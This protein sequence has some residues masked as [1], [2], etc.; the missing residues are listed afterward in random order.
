M[1]IKQKILYPLFACGFFG[2]LAL[3][4]NQYAIQQESSIRNLEVSINKNR[5]IASSMQEFVSNTINYEMNAS[6]YYQGIQSRFFTLM[7]PKLNFISK[8]ICNEEGTGHLIEESNK[9]ICNDFQDSIENI[10]SDLRN[11]LRIIRYEI[12]TTYKDLILITGKIGETESLL[13]K[14][15]NELDSLINTISDK[16]NVDEIFNNDEDL[17]MALNYLSQIRIFI[18][19]YS[20]EIDSKSVDFDE[21][22]MEMMN[23]RQ[24]LLLVA[25]LLQIISLICLLFFFKQFLASRHD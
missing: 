22:V 11:Y 6:S 25:V 15:L 18:N 4:I 21:Q 17:L 14:S 9:S 1:N 12:S 3:M 20:L 5:T 7:N 13:N 8:G 24:Q 19:Q 2:V 10:R 16:N 23:F